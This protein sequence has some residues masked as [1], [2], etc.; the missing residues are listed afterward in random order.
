MDPPDALQ[1]LAD[2]L[3]AITELR[4][5]RLRGADADLTADLICIVG[6]Q[7]THW[8]DVLRATF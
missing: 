6:K 8:Q 2:A 5:D 7:V 4:L 1:H 3:E